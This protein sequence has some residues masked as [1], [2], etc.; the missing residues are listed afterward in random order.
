MTCERW[1]DAIS[2]R[3]DGE[4]LGGD[5]RLLDDHLSRCPACQ[6]FASSAAA[7][8]RA[9]PIAVPARPPDLSRRVAKAVAAADRAGHRTL[10][11]ALLMAVGAGIIALSLPA[12]VLGEERDTA[13]H[14]AHHLGAFATAYGVGLLVV[15]VRPARAR[16]ML[17]VTVVLAG[18]LVMTATVDLVSGRIPLAGEAA[19]LPEVLSVALVWLLAVPP[20]PRTAPGPL[21]INR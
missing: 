15:A 11:R 10:A 17:P 9:W 13:V 4:A 2:A 19:H 3:L 7:E 18:A 16:T 14:A 12:L 21:V 5:P 1:R 8:R 20:R 6:A